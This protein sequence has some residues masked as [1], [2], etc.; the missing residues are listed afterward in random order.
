MTVGRHHAHGSF[1]Q[2]PQHTVQDRAALLC[3]HCKRGVVDE[4]VHVLA[5]DGPPFAEVDLRKA[6]KLIGRQSVQLEVA[7]SALQ[8]DLL[9]AC[10]DLDRLFRELPCDLLKLLPGRGQAS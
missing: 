6:W 4:S 1:T 7:P 10:R 8:F 3:G 2:L 5:R 9:T